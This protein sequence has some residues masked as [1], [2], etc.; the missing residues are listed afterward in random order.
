[1]RPDPARLQ[2]IARVTGGKAVT[3]DRIAKLPA[4]PNVRVAA[5]RHV[6][7]WLPAWSYTLGA[8][9][10]LAAHWLLRRRGGLP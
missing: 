9:L 8:A 3:G 7:P 4:V 6:V 5:E 10:L 2:R 1:M